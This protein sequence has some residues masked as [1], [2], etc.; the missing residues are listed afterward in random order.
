M[1]EGKTTL[2]DGVW[3]YFD[4]TGEDGGNQCVGCATSPN[5]KSNLC[6]RLPD[7]RGGVWKLLYEAKP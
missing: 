3:Y 1:S 6:E 5:D 2:L 4:T 7:C